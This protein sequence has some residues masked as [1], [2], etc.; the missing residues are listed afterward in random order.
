MA[1]SAFLNVNGMDWPCPR[2]G[3]EYEYAIA[4][5]SGRDANAA[6]TGQ[7]VGRQIV[8]LNAMEWVGL[9]PEEWAAMMRSLQ[10][11]FVPV[12]Y[13][14]CETQ[15]PKTVTMYPGNKTARPLF[16]Y[17]SSHEVEIYRNCKVNL[18][19]CGL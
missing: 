10:P 2:D 7:I 15:S 14:D 18:I 12:T 8:K 6:V 13:W 17:P 9:R 5:N 3:F 19:D 1:L 11:F 16:A 4:V